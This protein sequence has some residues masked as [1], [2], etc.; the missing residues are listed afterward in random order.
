MTIILLAFIP[1]FALTGQEGKLFHPLAFTKTF[2]VLAATVIAV[3]LVPVLCTILLG[4]KVHT[5]DANPVMRG[6]RSIYRPVLLTALAHRGLTLGVAALLLTGALLL[7]RNIGSEFMP[8]LNEGDLMF[9]PIAD[10]SISL[11]EN[12]TIAARQNAALMTFPEVASVVAKVARADTSTDPAPLNMTETIVHLKPR[13]QWRPGMTLDRLRAEMGSAA[14]LPGVSNIWTMPIINRID[15]LTTGL[16]SEVGVKIY[17]ND[18]TTLEELARQVANVVRRVPGSANVYPE[19]VT[20][21]QYLNIAVDRA[22]AARYGIGVGDVQQV[23]ETAI[24]EST[25]TTTIEGRQR[26]PVRVRYAPQFRTDPEALGRV[27]V[28]A[29]GGAFVPLSQLATIEHARGPAM[30]SSENGLLLATVLLNVQ[31]RDPGGFV[32]DARAAVTRQIRL[33]AG[34]YVSWSG[35][36]EN[37]ERARARLQV[38]LPVVLLVIFVLLYFTYHSALEAAHVLLAVPFAL[39]GGL[40]LVWL[41][42]YNF[43]V[44]VWVGFIALFG[45]AVQTGVVMVIYLEEAVERKR[46]ELGGVMTR[47]ALRE[48]VIEGALLR[49]RPKVMTVATVVAGLLPIMWS[50]RAGAEVMKPL[51]TPVLGGMASSLLHVLVVTPVIF[52][53]IQE[54][55]LGLQHESL[56]VTDRPAVNRRH[57]LIAAGAL[58]L[59]VLAASLVWR[60]ATR[61]RQGE[62]APTAGSVV[63]TV[64]AGALDVVVLSESGV[65]RTGRNAFTIEFRRTGTATLVDAGRVRASANMTMPG[66]AMSGNLQVRPS[67]VA[68]RYTATAEFGMA[69][70]WQMGVEW[71]GPAGNGSVSFQGGVQ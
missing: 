18:L 40:Y 20:S 30:I 23:I 59:V 8:P 55:R 11:E 34:Y 54:R 38:V 21:G 66:M 12:T 1:V 17:G 4:G 19:Q 7:A 14:Q 44:A 48:A 53:W 22:A 56:P 35:R 36:W 42:G 58:V 51:A 27:V 47:T 64:R 29:P 2:A 46:R 26:F 28:S 52:F 67:G 31:G 25:L 45:T 41:L 13:D 3:T 69:G 9:M 65:L 60:V 70:S 49:L 16:R 43:S 39:T 61:D 57:V 50:T 33:P 10:P 5:E 62:T 15:M 63:Q 32:N 37:Q 68:G 24:G 71:D 6:L